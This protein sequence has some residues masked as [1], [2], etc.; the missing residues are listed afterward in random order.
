MRNFLNPFVYFWYDGILLGHWSNFGGWLKDS[1]LWEV[2]K[3]SWIVRRYPRGFPIQLRFALY[4][5]CAG[6]FLAS[7]CFESFD[8]FLAEYFPV[9]M[10]NLDQ[11]IERRVPGDPANDDAIRFSRDEERWYAA[12]EIKDRASVPL[13]ILFWMTTGAKCA[14]TGATIGAGGASCFRH[15]W[16][17]S[18]E[19]QRLIRE[20]NS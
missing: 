7:F 4:G 17:Q 16:R 3:N 9:E 12:M 8:R 11:S 18:N 14:I 19:A 13:F 10:R 5:A 6:L 20:R 1:Y 2:S 15:I